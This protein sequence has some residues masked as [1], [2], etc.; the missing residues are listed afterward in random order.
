LPAGKTVFQKQLGSLIQQTTLIQYVRVQATVENSTPAIVPF[1]SIY[2]KK[3]ELHAADVS[4]RFVPAKLQ[5]AYL[6][7]Q[8]LVLQTSF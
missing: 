4:V 6:R 3:L 1:A 5:M 7:V 2:K 8:R